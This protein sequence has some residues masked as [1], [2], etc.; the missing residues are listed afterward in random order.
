VQNI[1]A[2]SVDFI[3]LKF[4]VNPGLSET[5]PWL[6][7]VAPNFD[8]YKFKSLKFIF[9]SS[10]ST[11]TTGTV[12]MAPEFDIADPL[13]LSKA[14]FLEYAYSARSA[15]WKNFEVVVPLHAIQNYREFYTRSDYVPITD[16]KLYDPLYWMVATDQIAEGTLVGELWIEYDIELYYPQTFVP[17]MRFVNYKKFIFGESFYDHSTL[18]TIFT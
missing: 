17:F 16:K 13:P 8:R 4:E 6:S 18:G 10:Q 9:E 14:S 12:M 7:G 3:P 5:F 2:T 11:L 15:V 1:K